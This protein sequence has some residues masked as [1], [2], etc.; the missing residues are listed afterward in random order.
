MSFFFFALLIV[1][2]L[3]K[4]NDEKQKTDKFAILLRFDS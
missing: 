1:S 4:G 3:K 2:K